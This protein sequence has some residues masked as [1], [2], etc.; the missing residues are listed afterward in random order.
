MKLLEQVE[1]SLDWSDANLTSHPTPEYNRSTGTHLMD[2]LRA[3]AIRTK[4]LNVGSSD[5]DDMPLR[6]LVGMGWEWAAVRLYKDVWWQPG[7]L[8][9]DG[10]YGTPDGLRDMN[11]PEVTEATGWRLNCVEEFK[12]TKKSL[13]TK[14][15]GPEQWKNITREWLWMAQCMGYCSLV[16]GMGLGEC[17][18]ARLH[19]LWANGN[20]DWASGGAGEKYVRYLVRF[21]QRELE[22]NW[23]MVTRAAT[24]GV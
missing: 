17:F 10:V 15:G 24:E 12:Y 7:E 4:Q 19:V 5:D 13:R 8:E 22:A 11:P 16:S 21:E 14:G 23:K 6:V 9:L 1:V 18:H 3:I 20:Y 2:V